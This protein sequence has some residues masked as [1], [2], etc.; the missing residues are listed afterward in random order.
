MAQVPVVSD[1]YHRAYDPVLRTF[2]V[3]VLFSNFVSYVYISLL[4]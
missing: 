4:G 2:F 3:E 1:V